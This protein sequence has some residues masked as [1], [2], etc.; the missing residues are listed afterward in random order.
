MEVWSE[1]SGDGCVFSYA[2]DA[3]YRDP[4]REYARAMARAIKTDRTLL[5]LPCMKKKLA[6]AARAPR[7]V[8]Y[9]ENILIEDELRKARRKERKETREKEK[10]EEKVKRKAE[11]EKKR[12]EK[13]EEKSE[14][15][16]RKVKKERKR[17]ENERKRMEKENGKAEKGTERKSEERKEEK[18]EQ[19]KEENPEAADVPVETDRTVKINRSVEVEISL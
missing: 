4:G 9:V 14:R 11:K 10:I 5:N 12:A 16:K 15:E 17:M 18:F 7:P 2:P 6:K 19:E 13:E 3:S 8:V 1:H